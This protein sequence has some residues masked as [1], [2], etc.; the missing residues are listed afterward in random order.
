MRQVFT[1]IQLNGYWYPSRKTGA[2]RQLRPL[3]LAPHFSYILWRAASKE[4]ALADG[5]STE[6]CFFFNNRTHWHSPLPTLP[7]TWHRSIATRET[8]LIKLPNILHISHPNDN[9]YADSRA[10]RSPI[11]CCDATVSATNHHSRLS[12]TT[13]LRDTTFSRLNLRSVSTGR[14]ST[15]IA[16]PSVKLRTVSNSI[17]GSNGSV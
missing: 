7:G 15:P 6:N 12:F 8:K 1:H 4:G 13:F 2:L 16:H 14:A 11:I 9:R 3:L 17:C 10:R 5:H